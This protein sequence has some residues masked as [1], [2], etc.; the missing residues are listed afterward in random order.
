MSP[1]PL[2]IAAMQLAPAAPIPN[3][4]QAPEVFPFP[5]GTKLEY[6]INEDD[7]AI[8]IEEVTEVK[9][10]KGVRTI[11]IEISSGD[12]RKTP[13]Y[14]EVRNGGLYLTKNANNTFDPPVLILKANA[15]KGDSW[16]ASYTMNGTKVDVACSVGDD[17]E[18]TTPAGKFKAMPITQKH[19]VGRARFETVNYYSRDGKLVRV[20]LDGRKHQELKAF[21]LGK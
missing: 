21:T 13:I 3:Q 4:A 20:L 15:K 14:Y 7:N 17:V 12:D 9:E 16:N 6:I 19:K 8:Q 1:L 18:L 5:V 11:K 10:V 2:L